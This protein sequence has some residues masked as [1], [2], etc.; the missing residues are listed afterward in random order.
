MDALDYARQQMAKKREEELGGQELTQNN[1][2]Q[3]QNE[4]QVNPIN[5]TAQA[6][7]VQ[8]I[9]QEDT[10]VNG[11]QV[12][13][14]DPT[15]LPPIQTQQREPQNIWVSVEDLDKDIDALLAEINSG[16]NQTTDE[17]KDDK[18]IDPSIDTSGDVNDSNKKSLDNGDWKNS[19]VLN[20]Q[21]ELTNKEIALQKLMHKYKV[22]TDLL[23][24]ELS[25]TK[26][27]ANQYYEKYNDAERTNKKFA[28]RAVPGKLADLVDSYKLYE[29][30]SDKLYNQHQ[31]V[32]NAIRVVESVT[33]RP[34]DN[35]IMD[36]FSQ[37]D[38][39]ESHGWET[40]IPQQQKQSSSND[41]LRM[42]SF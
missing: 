32:K 34:M 9:N 22:E 26:E 41:V 36:W 10:Q 31:L 15:Q 4:Q 21:E 11:T 25:S 28:N 13:Q 33:W 23:K 14:Q 30:G 35:Y 1:Q 12:N 20:L 17:D 5:I 6:N 27:R 2:Q 40:N 29:E 42:M 39:S 8:E 38:L 19:M 16:S 7:P 3:I 18:L 24:E 37:W